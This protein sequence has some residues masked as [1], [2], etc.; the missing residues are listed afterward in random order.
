MVWR[1]L[2]GGL[3]AAV[4]ALA[5][6]V[7]AAAFPLLRL[8]FNGD[9]ESLGNGGGDAFRDPERE[10]LLLKRPALLG[11]AERARVALS[12][13]NEEILS[14]RR[15]S[16][17]GTRA[18]DRQ[19]SLVAQAPAGEFFGGVHLTILAGVRRESGTTHLQ[20][21]RTGSLLHFD[22][23]RNVATIGFATALPLGLSLGSTLES[24]PTAVPGFVAEARWTPMPKVTLWALRRSVSYQYQLEV[25]QRMVAQIRAP[26]LM[27]E[28]DQV[29][30]ETE[31]GGEL[32]SRKS[33]WLR[34]G[35]EIEAPNDAWVEAGGRPLPNLSLQAGLDRAVF[36]FD[37]YMRAQGS[38]AIASVDLGLRRTR[39]FGGA[40][41]E[42][43]GNGKLV[44]RYI[45]GTIESASHADE[46]GTAAARAFLDVDLDLGLLLQTGHRLE[47]HQ[48]SFG[49][50]RHA[51]ERLGFA[52][53]VQGL[54]LISFPG[55][56]AI[57]SDTLELALV[58]EQLKPVS[59]DLL[60]LTGSVR[61]DVGS[62]TFS[63][64]VAQLIPVAVRSEEEPPAAAPPQ[65]PSEPRPQRGPP[66]PTG[67]A[68]AY[69]RIA[70]EIASSLDGYGGGSLVI[71]QAATSF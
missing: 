8:L 26:E 16:W 21:E 70:R 2:H 19:L 62:F 18:D 46:V 4:V 47:S 6:P 3:L 28:I 45:H 10:A 58:S 34:G 44:G 25:P 54:R 52:L 15:D 56:A 57:T 64:A 40:D 33:L 51:T 29:R 68:G 36:R 32:G 35:G 37:D 22:E 17:S 55:Q 59:I 31:L 12:L 42:L 27:Y 63:A 48:L 61:Y 53:G 1:R 13:E 49:W 60:G 9:V 7:P 69:A 30:R 43:G 20:S 5:I 41:L 65:P 67:P 23:A 38:G 71:L 24:G 66:P 39:L 50:D 14:I 11:R